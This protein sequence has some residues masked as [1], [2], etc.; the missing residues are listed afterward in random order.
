MTG[1]LFPPLLLLSGVGRSRPGEAFRHLFINV[2][3]YSYKKF[4]CLDRPFLAAAAC[5]CGSIGR[6]LLISHGLFL[7][8]YYTYV[9]ASLIY[10]LAKHRW[11]SLLISNDEMILHGSARRELIRL[12]PLHQFGAHHVMNCGWVCMID[13]LPNPF[14]P[15]PPPAPYIRDPGDRG[16]YS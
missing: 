6:K 13:G 15:N 9:Y 2:D 16:R 10:L 7:E 14:W 3:V 5:R 1:G 8:F 11:L 4:Y 12:K